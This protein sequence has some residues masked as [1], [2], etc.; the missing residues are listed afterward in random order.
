[1]DSKALTKVQSVALIAIIVVAAVGGG[2]AYVLWNAN[3]SN[4]PK[5]SRIGVCAD[6]DYY[7]TG[8][9]I[10]QGS[11]TAAEQ[12]NAEGG[13]L[14]RNFT[15]V[16]RRRRRCDSGLDISTATNALTKLITVDKADYVIS[17]QGIFE[18]VLSGYL[19]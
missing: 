15:V 14:G 5:T 3:S 7:P 11:H 16:A 1:M 18:Q 4:P 10:W 19:C 9:D 8:K 13:V 2:I 12:I 17:D 6:L